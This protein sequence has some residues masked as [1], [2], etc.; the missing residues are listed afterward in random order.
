MRRKTFFLEQAETLG[1]AERFTLD[2]FHSLSPTELRQLSPLVVG[3]KV[4]EY[5]DLLPERI[6]VQAFTFPSVRG[7]FFEK[8]K[9]VFA[10]LHS[11]WKLKKL[12][13]EHNARQFFSNTPRTHFVMFLAK[14]FFFLPGKW[15]VMI[16]DFTIPKFLL[17]NI[18]R[19]CNI[20]IAN[21]TPCR[22]YLRK[23]IRKSDYRKMRLIENG[24]DFRKIPESRAPEEIKNILLIGRI[25]PRKGQIFALQAA[26]LLQE[27]N[28]DIQFFIVGSSFPEDPRT[29]DYEKEIRTFAKDRN[30]QNVHFMG[31]TEDPFKVMAGADCV[32]ALPTEGETFGRIVTEGLAMQKLVLVFDEVG[33]RDIM[34]SFEQFI[35]T[36]TQKHLSLSCIT[37]KQN[38]MSLAEKIGFFADHP[39]KTHL[40]TDHARAFVQKRF[41][42]EETR[43]QLFTVF[44]EK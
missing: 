9:A 31:E 22:E 12:A 21:S 29:V 4:K 14:T 23:H 10:L 7:G 5:H 39:E 27:R 8:I 34:R 6:D 42:L 38:A 13:K 15:I 28:P 43:K 35:E 18:A 30:L 20:I 19:V 17:H 36:K 32:L 2:F 16:H 41:S 37:E 33:P 26:D 3:A 11:A 25:D 40:F 24:V 44:L 1:G